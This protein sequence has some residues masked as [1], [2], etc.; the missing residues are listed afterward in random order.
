[1]LSIV[2]VTALFS[3]RKIAQYFFVRVCVCVHACVCVSACMRVC[4]CV[5]VCVCVHACVCVCVSACMRVCFLFSLQF[6]WLD[7]LVGS[8]PSDTLKSRCV[9]RWIPIGWSLRHRAWSCA[10]GEER[11]IVFLRL[12]ALRIF[13]LPAFDGELFERGSCFSTCTCHPLLPPPPP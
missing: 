11:C 13:S 10:A 12:T 6:T 8:V 3:C 9:W 1:M 2:W 5:C 4:V 7:H